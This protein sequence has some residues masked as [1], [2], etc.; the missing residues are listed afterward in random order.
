MGLRHQH[1][2]FGTGTFDPVLRLDVARPFGRLQLG[3]L[4][5]GPHLALYENSQGFRAPATR[6]YGGRATA[7]LQLFGKLQR[8]LGPDVLYEGPER[9]DGVSGRTATSVGP[10]CSPAL[11]L[12]QNVR[13]RR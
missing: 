5:A 6:S 2:Q 1:I 3:G 7:G 8:R 9:W 11:A 10:R 13:A 12:S 4:R